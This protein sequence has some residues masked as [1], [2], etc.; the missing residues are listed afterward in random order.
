MEYDEP[1]VL[2]SQSSSY[3]GQLVDQTGPITARKLRD[4]A[5]VADQRKREIKLFICGAI[6]FDRAIMFCNLTIFIPCTIK[7]Y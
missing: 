3:L 1:H 2:L 5:F 7:K 6:K 4:I